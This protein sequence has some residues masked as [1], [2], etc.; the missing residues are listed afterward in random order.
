MSGVDWLSVETGINLAGSC[1]NEQCRLFDKM[2]IAPFGTGTF[3]I[4]VSKCVCP[5]CHQPFP[6]A[7]PMFFSCV[8]HTVSSKG[9][10]PLLQT[11]YRKVG[12]ECETYNARESGEADF[13]LVHFETHSSIRTLPRRAGSVGGGGGGDGGGGGCEEDEEVVV[14]PQRCFVCLE[15]LTPSDATVLRCMHGAH[16]KC[17]MEWMTSHTQCPHCALPLDIAGSTA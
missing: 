5:A 3:A 13:D 9:D 7:T 16:T 17:L 10:Q 14:V 2:V 6:P 11:P 8:Y 12:E 15:L 1:A 4:G